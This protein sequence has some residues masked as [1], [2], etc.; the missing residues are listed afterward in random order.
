M[1]CGV[2][3]VSV[4]SSLLR[5]VPLQKLVNRAQQEVKERGGVR[6]D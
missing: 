5:V 4:D 3:V 1:A 2:V 6:S